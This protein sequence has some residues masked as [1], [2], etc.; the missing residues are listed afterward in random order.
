MEREYVC[1]DCGATFILDTKMRCAAKRCPEC[2][3]LRTNFINSQ[4]R[5]R[6][7]KKSLGKT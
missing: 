7:R 3:R 6:E 5:E 2:A 1:I 4:W